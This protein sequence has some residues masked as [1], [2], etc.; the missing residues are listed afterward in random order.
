MSISKTTTYNIYKSSKIT[1]GKEKELEKCQQIKDKLWLT[2]ILL[3]LECLSEKWVDNTISTI[4][5][6]AKFRG[7]KIIY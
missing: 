2:C 5:M 7:E 4:N 3:N 1:V 6:S